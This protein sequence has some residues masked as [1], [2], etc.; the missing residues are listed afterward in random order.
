MSHYIPAFLCQ[1]I[2]APDFVSKFVFAESYTSLSKQNH[3]ENKQRVEISGKQWDYTI[4]YFPAKQG[5][6]K[7]KGGSTNRTIQFVDNE[8]RL[9]KLFNSEAAFKLYFVLI[10][11][12]YVFRAD[13]GS[14]RRSNVE[15]QVNHLHCTFYKC[16]ECCQYLNHLY[17]VFRTNKLFLN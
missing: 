1:K 13:E 4:R 2:V 16:V 9:K 15:Y 3:R 6:D 8:Y 10:A 7:K 5:I 11:M 17:G 12:C 14:L